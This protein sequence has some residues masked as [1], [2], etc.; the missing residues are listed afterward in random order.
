VQHPGLARARTGLAPVLLGIVLLVL[1]LRW[2]QS[3]AALQCELRRP[4]IHH[5]S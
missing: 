4:S 1:A 3:A 2:P 5:P